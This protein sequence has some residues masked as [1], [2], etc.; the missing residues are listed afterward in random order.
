MCAGGTHCPGPAATLVT[1]P[2][3]PW[4]P[5]PSEHTWQK[6]CS[7]VP[8]HSQCSGQQEH[9]L[10]SLLGLSYTSSNWAATSTASK[11]PNVTTE[12]RYSLS[13]QEILKTSLY[14]GTAVSHRP[15]G[16]KQN[17][18]LIG[19]SDWLKVLPIPPG[20]TGVS[21]ASRLFFFFFFWQIWI[22]RDWKSCS[23][24]PHMYS[25]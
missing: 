25:L 6:F 13:F 14:T 11:P 15:Q 8:G 17:A 7:G 24:S 16:R 20:G 9:W 22:S 4:P 5:W 18:P 23:H 19:N 12:P 21:S 10:M 2:R 3:C 1:Q